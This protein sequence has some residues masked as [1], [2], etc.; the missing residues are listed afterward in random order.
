[1]KSDY[2]YNGSSRII[3]M[4]NFI[5]NPLNSIPFVSSTTTFAFNKD[6]PGNVGGAKIIIDYYER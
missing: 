1:M 5:F 4:Y 6:S 2:N 3:F